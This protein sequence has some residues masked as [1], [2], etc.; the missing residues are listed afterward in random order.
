MSGRALH[1]RDG[2]LITNRKTDRRQSKSVP[3][4]HLPDFV[5]RYTLPASLSFSVALGPTGVIGVTMLRGDVVETSG[6][7]LDWVLG[8]GAAFLGA[9][10]TAAGQELSIPAHL[11]RDAYPGL[12]PEAPWRPNVKRSL[13]MVAV[14]RPSV[15][16]PRALDRALI[17]PVK[18]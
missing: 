18:R 2:K 4:E 1:L 15:V 8:Q 14:P 5:L 11:T 16:I 9:I 7:N 17:F 13:E 12:T 6:K 10:A 3:V